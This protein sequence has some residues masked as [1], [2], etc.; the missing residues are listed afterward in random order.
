M[1]P[2]KILKNTKAD[3]LKIVSLCNEI[4]YL[5]SNKIDNLFY[6]VLQIFIRLNPLNLYFYNL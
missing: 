5:K 1:S 3:N 4:V 6:Q 2:H